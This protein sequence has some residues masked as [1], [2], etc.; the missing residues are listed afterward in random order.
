M[1]RFSNLL[2]KLLLTTSR[3]KKKK[4]LFEYFKQA[5]IKDKAWAFTILTNRF[6]KKFLKV[7]ELKTLLK[8]KVDAELFKYSYDYV[9]DL[10]ETISL[11]WPKRKIKK[12]INLKLFELME[13]LE[14]KQ[15]KDK[16]I[17]ELTLIL[18]LSY[19]QQR[20]TIIKILTGG[21]RVGVS[22]GL[23]KESLVKY[24][25][26]SMSEIEEFWYGFKFPYTDLF[27]WLV[28]KELPKYINKKQLFNSFIPLIIG[29]LVN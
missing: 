16:L 9:G 8:S 19:E 7:I 28:G 6:E 12:E 20:F 13:F 22:V 15:D 23:I 11:I 1:N 5:H 2:N 24:G 14:K 27:D 21:L 29:P 18:D 26:R 3:N 17:K 4:I 10:A 25:C